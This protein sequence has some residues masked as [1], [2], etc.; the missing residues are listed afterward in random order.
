MIR[1]MLEIVKDFGTKKDLILDQENVDYFYLFLYHI[2]EKT[3][4]HTIY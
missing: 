2:S 4:K 3:K 1:K